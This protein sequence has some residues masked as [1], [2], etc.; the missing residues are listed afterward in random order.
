MKN[1]NSSPRCSDMQE[2][3]E[4]VQKRFL[5][6]AWPTGKDEEWRR[7]DPDAMPW[8]NLEQNV[9]PVLAAPDATQKEF[10]SLSEDEA[11]L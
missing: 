10:S 1:N 7:S 11:L 6:S 8:K 5:A 2:L 4:Q 3:R 9:Q